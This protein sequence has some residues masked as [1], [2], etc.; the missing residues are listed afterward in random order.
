M[1]GIEKRV[2]WRRLSDTFRA[3]LVLIVRRY[4]RYRIRKKSAPPPP[5]L[6][7]SSKISRGETRLGSIPVSPSA[8]VLH[9]LDPGRGGTIAMPFEVVMTQVC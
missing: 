8:H 5:N 9:R 7:L 1:S 6:M 2:A 4:R 3:V